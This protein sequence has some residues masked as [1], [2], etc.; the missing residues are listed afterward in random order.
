MIDFKKY[1]KDTIRVISN[2][3]IFNDF[4]EYFRFDF[5]NED[6]YRLQDKA[7]DKRIRKY[8]LKKYGLETETWIERDFYMSV[9]AE[10]P[11]QLTIRVRIL[12]ENFLDTNPSY[13]A[14]K[15]WSK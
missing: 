3:V 1:E 8:L 7:I 10:L 5:Y 4:H 2:Y 9:N 6:A 11:L 15:V 12:K 13:K 14:Y